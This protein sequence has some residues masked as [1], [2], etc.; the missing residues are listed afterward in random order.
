M[1]QIEGEICI[2]KRKYSSIRKKSNKWKLREIDSEIDYIVI[3]NE[4]YLLSDL[5]KR[6]KLKK[7]PILAKKIFSLWT[8]VNPF[9]IP[10]ISRYNYFHILKYI[11]KDIYKIQLTDET[12]EE[13]I[14]NDVNIDF[15]GKYCLYFS[16]FY[17]AIFEI[18]DQTTISKTLCEYVSQVSDLMLSL[19]D[20]EMLQGLNLYNKAHCKGERPHYYFWMK[21]CLQINEISKQQNK[22]NLYNKKS[23]LPIIKTSKSIYLDKLNPLSMHKKAIFLNSSILE[24]FI[25]CRSRYLEFY[26]KN[27]IP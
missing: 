19:K 13:N 24:D 12:I 5:I 27:K 11:Y 6:K 1:D 20:S 10:G 9:G 26:N 25:Q 14:D 8:M 15:K 4:Y 21:D 18:I 17:D 16:W 23:S 22:A 2:L 7:S 3:N